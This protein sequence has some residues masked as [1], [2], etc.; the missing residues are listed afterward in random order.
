M[1]GTNIAVSDNAASVPTGRRRITTESTEGEHRGDREHG[2]NTEKL[3]VPDRSR[4]GLTTEITESTE[5][6][7]RG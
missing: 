2:G 4:N 5:K 6:A 7:Q 3:M 1:T